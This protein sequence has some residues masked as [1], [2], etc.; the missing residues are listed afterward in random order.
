MTNPI[1]VMIA[2]DHAVVR[3][4]IRAFLNN[5]PEL[6]VVGEACNGQEAVEQCRALLPEVILMDLRM[7]VM[8][9]VAATRLIHRQF[10]QVQ[11]IALTTF[12]DKELVH[13][14]LEAGAI[15][16]LI[17][18]V[19]GEEL[20][21]AIRRAH[22]G[23]AT[24]APEAVQALVKSLSGEPTLGQDLTSREREVLALLVKGL[25]NNGIAERLGIS[26]A[27]AKAHVSSILSKLG[28]STRT[29]ATALALEKKLLGG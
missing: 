6:A 13:D 1:S 16:Y 10:P 20:A 21:E 17:K 19:S 14:A 12:Q 15:S 3:R 11:V 24:L 8:D 5:R 26:H 22:E 28:V 25:S 18:N 27:T 4:G 2:D 7:P 9:G 29:E 23:R